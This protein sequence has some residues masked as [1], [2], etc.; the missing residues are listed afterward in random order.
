MRAGEGAEREKIQSR[1]KEVK[2]LKG[3]VGW[4]HCIGAHPLPPPLHR[5]R[6]ASWIRLNSEDIQAG[7]VRRGRHGVGRCGISR[8]SKEDSSRSESC[9]EF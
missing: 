7:G 2:G 9:L 1:G 6:G 4:E 8:R 5:Q 3:R